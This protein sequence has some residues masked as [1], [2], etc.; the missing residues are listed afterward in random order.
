MACEQFAEAGMPVDEARFRIAVTRVA[1]LPRA[2]EMPAGEKGGRGYALYEIGELQR[3]H[4]ALAPWLVKDAPGGDAR[5]S[6][7]GAGMP[8]P[9]ATCPHP[10]AGS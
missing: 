10:P 5:R 7:P 6:S 9:A 8:L 2:G 3:L 4:S 1:R